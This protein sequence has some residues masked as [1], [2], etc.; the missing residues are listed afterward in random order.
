MAQQLAAPRHCCTSQPGLPRQPSRVNL[1]PQRRS[2]MQPLSAHRR[3]YDY[4]YGGSSDGFN[5]A[6]TS[7][8]ASTLGELLQQIERDWGVTME[9]KT[10]DGA[11]ATATASATTSATPSKTVCPVDSMETDDDISFFVDVPGLD[12]RDLKIQVNQ[13]DKTMTVSGERFQPVPSQDPDLATTKHI[14]KFERAFGTFSRTVTLPE[15][16]DPQLISAKVDKGVLRIKVLK[17]IKQEP[18][19]QEVEID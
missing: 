5:R 17:Q 3:R 11:S 13:L 12:K 2:V 18:E 6:A 9:A 1:V 16:A 8:M 10:K 19:I 15:T 4:G 7:F 14:N